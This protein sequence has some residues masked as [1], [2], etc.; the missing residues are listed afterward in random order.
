[1]FGRSIRLPRGAQYALTWAVGDEWG[2]MT[3]AMLHRSAAFARLAR[4]PVT[5]L[6]LDPDPDYP[7]RVDRLRAERRL[8]EGVAILNLWDWLREHPLPG[9]SLRLE[10]HAFTPLTELDADSTERIEERRRGERVLSRVRRG[11]DGEIL[12]TDHY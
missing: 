12:Q 6:T 8:S 1:M 4:A 3:S 5:V 9:G 7:S 10:R 2:G 11:S